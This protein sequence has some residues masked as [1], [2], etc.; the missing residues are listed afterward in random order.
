[1]ITRFISKWKNPTIVL[2]PKK[3]GKTDGITTEG[4]SVKFYSHFL[5]LDDETDKDTIEA[6]K[7]G[8]SFGLDYWV[9]DGKDVP[10]N[11]MVHPQDAKV[12]KMPG[13]AEKDANLAAQQA[14]DIVIEKRMNTLEERLGGLMDLVE[15]IAVKLDEDK[16]VGD[17]GNKKTKE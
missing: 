12:S 15:K 14:K 5:D 17:K 6:L 4:K 3:L 11:V 8:K 2:E 13:D 9:F 7:K 16:T 10:K 1:M